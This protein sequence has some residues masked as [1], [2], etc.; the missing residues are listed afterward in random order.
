VVI[1]VMR[2]GGRSA[3]G[4][5]GE[6]RIDTYGS[7][8]CCAVMIGMRCMVDQALRDERSKGAECLE[9]SCI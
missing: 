4:K 7:I 2:R 5:E 6:G 9:E 1:L 8:Y 3:G